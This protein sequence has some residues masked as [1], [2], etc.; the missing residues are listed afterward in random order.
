MAFIDLFIKREEPKKVEEPT[1]VAPVKK[2][3]GRP[4]KKK[5]VEE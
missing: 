4:P 5:K 3:R 1:P 2:K